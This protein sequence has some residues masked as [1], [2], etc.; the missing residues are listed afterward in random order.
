MRDFGD[1]GPGKGESLT[2]FHEQPF[3][4]TDKSKTMHAN[5]AENMLYNQFDVVPYAT[6]QDYLV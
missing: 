4:K 1:E 2:I 5:H 6:L 3:P